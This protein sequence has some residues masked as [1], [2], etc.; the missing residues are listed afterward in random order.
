MRYC[1]L[2]V[3]VLTISFYFKTSMNVQVKTVTTVS[4]NATI[5]RVHLNVAAVL[6]IE[7]MATHVMVSYAFLYP[8]IRSIK[9]Y[10]I[11]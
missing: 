5:R 4:S 2:C 1:E 9:C 6:V 10:I 11:R 3:S 7:S 8:H